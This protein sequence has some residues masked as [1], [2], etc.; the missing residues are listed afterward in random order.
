MKSRAKCLNFIL[1]NYRNFILIPISH[2]RFGIKEVAY[3]HTF[4]FGKPTNTSQFLHQSTPNTPPTQDN[5]LPQTSFYFQIRPISLSFCHCH[6]NES[7][8]HAL[9]HNIIIM[10][11]WEDNDY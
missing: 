6:S 5:L 1:E 2:F 10:N 9:A 11:V 8:A 4:I 7:T 3:P